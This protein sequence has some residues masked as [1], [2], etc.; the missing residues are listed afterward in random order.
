MSPIGP[1]NF[2]GVKSRAWFYLAKVW[3]A[4]GYFDR[5]IESL[6]KVEGLLSPRLPPLMP[7]AQGRPD[8]PFHGA[9][10][11]SDSWS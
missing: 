9:G 4:R 11:E 7:V 5:S 6:H 3:Y 8:S 10:G 1:R 2:S